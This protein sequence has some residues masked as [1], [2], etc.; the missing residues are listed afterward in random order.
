MVDAVS[1]EDARGS[2]IETY[3]RSDFEA[4]G[5]ACEFV[6]DN[7]VASVRGV[8]RGMHYQIKRPQAKLVRV[9]KG[10]VFDVAVDLRPGSPTYG[11]WEEVHLSASNR[12]QLFIPR[13]F[14]HGYLVL[15]ESAELCYKCDEAYQ[16]DDEGGIMWNDPAL[17]IEWPPLQGDSTFD[18]TKLIISS[19]DCNH[20][21]FEMR[22]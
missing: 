2:F 6:Q 15:S 17:G 16:P 13:G 14:A 20:P 10:D 1:Y 3:K 9:I 11:K 7:H 8:L 5:I 12:R 4:G 19:K 18:S 22:A 21:P